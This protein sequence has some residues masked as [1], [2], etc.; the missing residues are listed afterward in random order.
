MAR[1]GLSY[2]LAHQL[3]NEAVSALYVP[4]FSRHITYTIEEKDGAN[5]RGRL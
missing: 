5:L 2:R 4:L 3:T 1:I